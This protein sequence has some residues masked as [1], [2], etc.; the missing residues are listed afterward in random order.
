MKMFTIEVQGVRVPVCEECMI[1]S[2]I[3]Y[4]FDHR[5]G[6]LGRRDCKNVSDDGQKQ[7]NC[8]E[9][10]PELWTAIS[11]GERGQ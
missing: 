2:H 4:G 6:E 9:D 3:S 11:N 8:T 1:G 10:W 5:Q 7:C